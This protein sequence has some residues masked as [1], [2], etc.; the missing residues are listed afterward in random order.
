MDDWCYSIHEEL[1]AQDR[2]ER[3]AVT[4]AALRALE[5]GRGT[6]TGAVGDVKTIVQTRAINPVKPTT[7]VRA[8]LIVKTKT[9]ARIPIER[10]IE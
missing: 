1:A 7:R 10:R 9:E 8:T 2:A 3:A 4:A 5:L 6:G